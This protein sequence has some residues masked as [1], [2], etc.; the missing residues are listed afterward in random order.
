MNNLEHMRRIIYISEI[1]SITEAAAQLH[2]SQP[3]LS[4]MIISIEKEIG[5]PIFD[6]RQQPLK[7]TYAGEL[8]IQRA[9]NILREYSQMLYDIHNFKEGFSGKISIGISQRRS[10]QII[11]YIIPE[12]QQYFPDIRYEFIDDTPSELEK[13]L[14]K[15]KID[16]LFAKNAIADNRI[17]STRLCREHIMLI[18]SKKSN[19]Y[20]NY[21]EYEYHGGRVYKSLPITVAADEKFFLLKNSTSLRSICNSIFL[22]SNISPNILIEADST[23]LVNSLAYYLD[24]VGLV[25]VILPKN[26]SLDAI[27]QNNVAYFIFSPEHMEL[28]LY[29]SYY[30]QDYLS[31]PHQAFIEIVK[32]KF[33]H[34]N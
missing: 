2:I 23:D 33:L 31:P 18:A 21:S 7:L 25:S 14:T 20:K 27:K 22:Q 16:L 28:E 26:L 34:D 9:N 30:K 15:G 13:L 17:Q 8:Y 12:M 1:G 10:K 24:C 6:R 11:P 19:L 5:A 29:M 4:Q 3:S 32:Q